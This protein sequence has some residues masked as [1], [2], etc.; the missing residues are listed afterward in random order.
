MGLIRY[1]FWVLYTITIG[2][3]YIWLYQTGEFNL[4]L[5][6]FTVSM[7]HRAFLLTSSTNSHL[8]LLQCSCVDARAHGRSVLTC[9]RT[10]ACSHAGPAKTGNYCAV[11]KH[12]YSLICPL[13]PSVLLGSTLY[14]IGTAPRTTPPT[15]P[16]TCT[17]SVS[18]SPGL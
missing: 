7:L 4:I 5:R 3:I 16:H 8:G 9:A 15:R 17:P 6:I 12:H 1:H 10:Q 14:T 13:A 18:Q 2:D 11:V